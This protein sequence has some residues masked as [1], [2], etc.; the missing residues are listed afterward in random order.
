MAEEEAPASA[1]CVGNSSVSGLQGK[2]GGKR[3]PSIQPQDSPPTSRT[4]MGGKGQG[5]GRG[6]AAKRRG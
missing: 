3:P 5:D 2:Q 4:P 1:D 6:E